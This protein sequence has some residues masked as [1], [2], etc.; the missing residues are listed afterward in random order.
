MMLAA[1]FQ[2]LVIEVPFLQDFVHTVR[3]SWKEWL[4]ASSLSLSVFLASDLF[5]L[6]FDIQ[7]QEE[8]LLEDMKKK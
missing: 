4:C 8:H 3:L 7:E 6:I 1:F 2:L 5:K